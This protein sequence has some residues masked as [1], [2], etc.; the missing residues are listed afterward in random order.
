MEKLWT[1]TIDMVAAPSDQGARFHQV[2]FAS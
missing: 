1:R 2:E